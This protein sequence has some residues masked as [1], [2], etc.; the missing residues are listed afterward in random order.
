MLGVS[1]PNLREALARLEQEGLLSR[2]RGAQTSVNSA[3]LELPGRFD[4]RIDFLTLLEEAGFDATVDVLEDTRVDLDEADAAFFGV[5]IGSPGLRL[6]KRWRAGGATAM[7]ATDLMPIPAGTELGEVLSSWSLFELV[8]KILGEDVEWEIAVPG[9]CTL[10]A[11]LATLMDRPVGEPVLTIDVLGI[12]RTGR[13]VYR[14][15]EH[16]VPTFLRQGMIRSRRHD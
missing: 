14:A 12:A 1:R 2:R 7:V 4:Q 16:H 6:V 13:R 15:F 9:A 11:H 8:P 10:D 3:A 5:P